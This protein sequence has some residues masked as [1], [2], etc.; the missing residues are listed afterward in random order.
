MLEC[1]NRHISLFFSYCYVSD[2]TTT[3]TTGFSKVYQHYQSSFLLFLHWFMPQKLEIKLI[4]MKNTGFTFWSSSSFLFLVETP[5]MAPVS[6]P[7]DS[8]S[9][10]LHRPGHQ[11]L[12]RT[13][14]FHL[15][16][17]CESP[18]LFIHQQ[19]FL[20]PFHSSL[21]TDQHSSSLFLKSFFSACGNLLV[22][23]PHVT[24]LQK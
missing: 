21:Y 24:K 5:R 18:G 7:A 11:W 15:P 12:T 9:P 19:R 4:N 8:E 14:L 23:P 16:H 3:N 6:V 2:L 1:V 17:P 20:H 10:P 22:C 13:A